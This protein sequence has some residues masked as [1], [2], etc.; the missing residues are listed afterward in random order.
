MAAPPLAQGGLGV[1]QPAA[2]R[3][4]F[5]RQASR[6]KQTPRPADGVFAAELLATLRWS[7]VTL[8]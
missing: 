3:L 7:R 5:H 2:F 8:T 4:C 1:G 6:H